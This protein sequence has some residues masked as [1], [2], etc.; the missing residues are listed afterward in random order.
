MKTFTQKC[1][2]CKGLLT[3]KGSDHGKSGKCAHC[4]TVNK[5][6]YPPKAAVE[7]KL[8]KEAV[9]SKKSRERV[10]KKK[11]AQEEAAET[12]RKKAETNARQKSDIL[13]MKLKAKESKVQ[14]PVIKQ[15]K[16]LNKPRPATLSDTLI[17]IA[18]WGIIILFV[19]L[20]FPMMFLGGTVI[21][22]G[23]VELGLMI[24]FGY[25]GSF[26]GFFA[27]VL[28]LFRISYH[29]RQIN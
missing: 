26:A 7:N 10:E 14:P 4:G 18:E 28:A 16:A 19:V 13:K 9:R 25:I 27:P 21:A 11:A 3:F 6:S 1:K 2:G 22:N 24:I 12:A 15:T 23:E 20:L 17:Q 5:I 29:V 8:A